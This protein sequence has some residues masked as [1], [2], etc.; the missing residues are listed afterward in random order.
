MRASFAIKQWICAALALIH[1]SARADD[2]HIGLLLPLESPQLTTN[3]NLLSFLYANVGVASS[4]TG[5]AI[6]YWVGRSGDSPGE[7]PHSLVTQTNIFLSRLD[8]DG[9]PMIEPPRPVFPI[10]YATGLQIV[11]ADSFFFGLYERRVSYYYGTNVFVGGFSPN[12]AARF[13]PLLLS[14]N[15]SNYKVASNGRTLLYIQ[16]NALGQTNALD[17]KV[18]NQDGSILSR[19]TVDGSSQVSQPL[20]RVL[21]W[22]AT[23]A[24]TLWF[25]N[26]VP[27]RSFALRGLS[28][29]AARTPRVH[30]PTLLLSSVRWARAKMAICYSQRRVLRG[31]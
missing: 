11:G 12:G 2:L 13:E 8:G 14:T 29:T 4:R 23:A 15:A 3:R 26:R 1:S 16:R 9:L 17:F 21:R 5:A 18:L 10:P 20:Q 22:P 31:I 19:G 6:L 30:I 25:G 27:V 7:T 24:I 28:E